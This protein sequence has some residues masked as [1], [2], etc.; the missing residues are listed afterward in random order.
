MSDSGDEP[1]SS[2]IA[3]LDIETGYVLWKSQPLVA[4][5]DNFVI[6]DNAVICGYGSTDGEGYL[7]E[8]DINTGEAVD[9]I[10]MDKKPDYIVMSGAV[11]YVWAYD[12]AY[13]FALSEG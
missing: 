7:Y 2:Y 6:T 4:N 8:L 12:T 10:K 13:E 5:A 9:K 11:L 3:K 1:H